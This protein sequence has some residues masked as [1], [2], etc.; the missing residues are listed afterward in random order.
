MVPTKFQA[1]TQRFKPCLPV[2]LLAA[3]LLWGL[4]ATAARG[5]ESRGFGSTSP[6]GGADDWGRYWAL[7]IG[8]NDYSEWPKLRTAEHDARQMARVL[9]A[10]YGF[11]SDHIVLRLNE[12]ATLSTMVH[13]LRRIA[14]GLG[15][16]DNW[17]IYFAGHGQIDSLTNEG[18]WIPVDGK[19]KDPSSWLSHST[20]K[21]ILGSDRV[22]ARSICVVAD[23]C[24]A[25]TLL[26]GGPGILNLADQLYMEKL[27]ELAGKRSRQVVTSGGVEPV[28]DGG[29]DGH[30]LFAYYLL[31]ALKENTRPVIDLENLFHTRVWKPVAEISGQTPSLGRLR[32]P[33]DEDGQFVLVRT[34]EGAGEL[35]AAVESLL[36]RSHAETR[37]EAAPDALELERRAYEGIQESEDV[38]RWHEFLRLFPSGAYAEMAAQR[39]ENLRRRQALEEARRTAAEVERQRLLEM[40]RL[41]LAQEAKELDDEAFQVALQLGT[42]E[43]FHKYLSDYPDGAYVGEAREHLTKA[44]EAVVPPSPDPAPAA[45]DPAVLRVEAEA[46]LLE[47]IEQTDS[48]E[49]K[50]RLA[51]SFL[52]QF[53]DSGKAAFAHQLVAID[54]RNNNDDD[55]FF[56]HAEESLK[57]IPNN[58]ALL[59]PLAMG[60]AEKG[61]AERAIELA[62]NGIQVLDAVERP[63]QISP[64]EWE[65]RK[66]LLGAELRYALGRAYLEKAVGQAGGDAQADGKHLDQAVVFLQEAV[67]QNPAHDYATFRLAFARARQGHTHEALQWYARTV[68]I[69]GTASDA[70][71]PDLEALYRAVNKS[72]EGLEELIAEQKRILEGRPAREEPRE[73]RAPS[74]LRP[75]EQK[76]P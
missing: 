46:A 34:S 50:V 5:Q 37:G 44:T 48:W 51:G 40:E 9:E 54:A 67:Q 2:L 30:S 45:P 19:M 41:R 71:R 72:A 68:A 23:S 38:D 65:Q 75:E 22:R 33:M 43:A 57:G 66:R 31:R 56:H 14:E 55:R 4:G 64:P 74:L 28:M 70:A 59:I 36:E 63:P 7:I 73:R 60:Y 76:K 52:Q 21:L 42:D 16:E 15:P 3:A 62:S 6:P 53:P 1:M 12:E 58:L 17:L 29:R 27:R 25:G 10:H 39:I 24:Y 47:E 35:Q 69:G 26:R 49:G 18:Y 8:V 61:Q 32:T 11:Q 13:D 20:V